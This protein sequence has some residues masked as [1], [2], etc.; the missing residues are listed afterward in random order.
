MHRR[1]LIILSLPLWTYYV[2]SHVIADGP[3]NH[4]SK[5]SISSENT[6]DF[7]G[8]I[9]NFTQRYLTPVIPS[10][11]DDS[12]VF[13][14]RAQLHDPSRDLI[15][16]IYNKILPFKDT[17]MEVNFF[18]DLSVTQGPGLVY[19]DLFAKSYPMEKKI[20]MT[21]PKELIKNPLQVNKEILKFM[22]EK[23]FIS[24]RGQLS[25]EKEQIGMYI[26]QKMG[27]LGL[28]MYMQSFYE[29]V[30]VIY[31]DGKISKEGGGGNIIGILPGEHWKTTFDRPIIIGAHW[32]TVEDTSGFGDNSS[33][34]SALLEVASV[35]TSAACYKN[36]HSVMFVAFDSEE[37]GSYGSLEFIRSYLKPYFFDE[38]I[39]LGGAYILDTIGNYDDSPGSQRIP[40]NWDAIIPNVVQEI[41]D[42]E[43]KGDFISVI[44]R[45]H[46]PEEI[47][48]S[49]TFKK[50]MKLLDSS[51][52]KVKCIELDLKSLK[53]N[54]LPELEDLKDHVTFL[55]SD[56]AR[57]WFYHDNE[58][59]YSFP[60][61]LI[62]DTGGNRGYMKK[63]YHHKCDSFDNEKI[64]PRSYEFLTKVAQSVALSV[65]ELTGDSINNCNVDDLYKVI[66]STNKVMLKEAGENINGIKGQMP[67]KKKMSLMEILLERISE[68]E[69]TSFFFERYQPN[70]GNQYNIDSLTIKLKD[71]TKSQRNTV[72]PISNINNLPGALSRVQ[73]LFRG[74]NSPVMLFL[75]NE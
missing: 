25:I 39:H 56:H 49:Y 38:G 6:T 54:S 22:L 41:L 11:K 9:R 42:N 57:F 24:P 18:K 47:R 45:K 75:K 66:T 2:G 30:P 33:G 74:K 14:Y 34:L 12:I 27:S 67:N 52:L 73:T 16:P 69:Q 46:I 58:R 72:S 65:I 3:P 35:L 48:L 53:E 62:T 23:V 50:Y 4:R 8:F 44:S 36:K 37:E 7:E 20:R 29:G 59:A 19:V 71:D 17:F 43:E 13:P 60:G 61:V 51:F 68:P 63:C 10:L 64:H 21:S 55:T 5:F 70:Y 40:Y 1:S 15:N 31:K 26:F 28:I 32:D